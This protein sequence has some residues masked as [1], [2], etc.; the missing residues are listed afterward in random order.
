MWREGLH[1]I[2]HPRGCKI[3]ADYGQHV[4]QAEFSMDDAFIAVKHL[5]EEEEDFWQKKATRYMD[6]LDDMELEAHIRHLEGRIRDMEEELAGP[7]KYEDCRGNK[8][9]WY[10]SSNG[11][12]SGVASLAPLALAGEACALSSQRESRRI[13]TVLTAHIEEDMQMEDGE[14]VFPL[15]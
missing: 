5:M 12:G 8:R 9:A 7:H 3:C 15:P 11:M 6:D 2:Y 10:D 13:Q 14:V 1:I 4:M